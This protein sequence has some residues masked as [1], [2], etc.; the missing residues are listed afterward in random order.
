MIRPHL[1]RGNQCE[2]YQF[3]LITVLFI[4][5]FCGMAH[6]KWDDIAAYV[7]A[8]SGVDMDAGSTRFRLAKIWPMALGT[9]N[10]T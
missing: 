2:K 9:T 5:T 4:A 8:V 6:A 1:R 10:L 7:K 3:L